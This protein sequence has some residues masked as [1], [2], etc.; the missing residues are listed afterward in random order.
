MQQA[1]RGLAGAQRD[2]P[3]AGLSRRLAGA[4]ATGRRAQA[5]AERWLGDP[6]LWPQVWDENRYILD[7]HWIYPGDPI[8]IDVAVQ[9]A[10]EGV[11][12]GGEISVYY[13]PMIAKI[14]VHGPTRAVALSRLRRALA[15]TEVAGTVTNLGFLGALAGHAGF[16]RG[17]VDTGLIARDIDTLVAAPQI[18][19]RLFQIT[20][21]NLGVRHRD[22]RERRTRH[23]VRRHTPRR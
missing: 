14:T 13:D 21:Q 10:A 22:Q 3:L 12:E 17:E 7:S 2:R 5:E 11:E 4:L 9:E 8:V 16:G 18:A 20:P 19:P 6:Y 23:G 1:L 15:A